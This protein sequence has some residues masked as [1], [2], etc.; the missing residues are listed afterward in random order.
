MSNHNVSSLGWAFGGSAAPS[1]PPSG[2]SSN[3][4]ASGSNQNSGNVITDRSTTRIHAAPGG[5]SSLSLAFDPTPVQPSVLKA[6]PVAAAAPA[7]FSSEPVFGTRGAANSSNRYANGSNQNSG[8]VITDRSTTRIHAAPGGNSSLSLAFD[9][10]PVAAKAAPVVAG[11]VV[12]AAS[13]SEPVF[14]ARTAAN[15]ANRY[16]NGSN[17]NC[18]N[19]ITDRS[20]TRIHAPPGGWSQISFGSEPA[21][22]AKPAPLMEV[23]VSSNNNIARAAPV[24]QKTV[25][26]TA[27]VSSNSYAS[28][29]NQNCNNFITDRSTTRVAA[30]PGG[31]SS[32]TLG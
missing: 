10:K 14:G 2:I 4:Y 31:R 26:V 11:P 13:S 7:S 17:Q 15:S 29:S 16:A 18:G 23:I 27:S 9:P 25:P 32:F 28:G 6:A 21:V 8:N 19:V 5:N 1:A 22:A 24:A 3:R 12:V 20:T 30:P